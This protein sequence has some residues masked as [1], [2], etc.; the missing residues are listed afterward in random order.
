MGRLARLFGWISIGSSSPQLF[1]LTTQLNL[2]RIEP[3]R[4]DGAKYAG[5]YF[6]LNRGMSSAVGV[7]IVQ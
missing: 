7:F 6:F 2:G 1:V 5:R 3:W 4:R